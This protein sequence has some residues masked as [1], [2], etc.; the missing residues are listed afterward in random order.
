MTCSGCTGAVTRVLQKAE[1]VSSF[2]VSLDKQEVLV[3]GTIPYDTL[4]EKIKKTGK[5]V[6]SGETL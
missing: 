2:D 4:L 3:T 6:R 5:E 1:G